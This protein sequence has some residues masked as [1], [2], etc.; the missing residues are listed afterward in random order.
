[1]VSLS[2]ESTLAGMPVAPHAARLAAPA[3]FVTASGDLFGAASATR[4]FYR[5]CPAPAKR[6][7]VVPGTAHGTALLASGA[8]A[9]D[10]TAFLE[11]NVG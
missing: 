3:L 7:V 1:V 6:L 9:R 10:V 2:A 5:S 4:A 8:V 11:R